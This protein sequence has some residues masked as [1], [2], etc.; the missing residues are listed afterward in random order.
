MNYL[1]L[2]SAIFA[3]AAALFW[4]VSAVI[5]TPERFAIT[6]VAPDSPM[7]QPLGGNP[8]GGIHVGQAYSADLIAL[9]NAL[10]R[11]SK[12]SAWAAACAGISALLQTVQLFQ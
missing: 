2:L 10:R 5:Q 1:T 6:V 12:L 11:Q 7:G 3:V 4:F 8:L 9:A